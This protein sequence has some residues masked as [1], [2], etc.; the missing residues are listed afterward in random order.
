MTRNDAFAIASF[1]VSVFFAASEIGLDTETKYLY[2]LI[3]ALLALVLTSFVS[4]KRIFFTP[5]TK[6]TAFELLVG[7]GNAFQRKSGDIPDAAES[8]VYEIVM[9]E[10]DI[11]GW[12]LE[13]VDGKTVIRRPQTTAEVEE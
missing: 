11:D 6:E 13:I 5:A 4:A 2:T 8:A 1:F 9:D 3:F 12:E 7:L 10:L